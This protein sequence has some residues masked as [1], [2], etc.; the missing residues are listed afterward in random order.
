M[1]RHGADLGYIPVIV[2]D[3]CGS[4]HDDAAAR[5]LAG[6]EF[7][8][9]ALFTDVETICGQFRRIQSH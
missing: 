6:L 3:A 8:G 1:V 2:N 9:D 5:S 4:G 7:S